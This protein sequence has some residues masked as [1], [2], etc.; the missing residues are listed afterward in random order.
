MD[1]NA[2]FL[3]KYNISGPRYTSYPPAN[4]FNPGFTTSDY[5]SE[6]RA[7]NQQKPASISLY[8]HIPF[9]PQRCHFCGCSTVIAQRKKVVERY[10]Q[11]LKT[12]MKLVASLLD[13]TRRVTQIHWG[14]GTPNSISMNYIREIMDWIRTCFTV[15]EKAEIAI[16][17][18]PA[19]LD[20]SH[21]DQLADIGF[22]RISLGIQDF[23]EDVL[24]VVNREAPRHPVKEVV[25]YLRTK[26]FRGINLDFIYGLPLQ[27]LESFRHTIDQAIAIRPDRI[28]TFS[29]AHVP[30]VKA[31]QKQLE[32][33]GLPDA[34][35]KMNLFLQATAQLKEAGYCAIGI[36]HFTLPDDDLTRA[37]QNKQLHRNFQGY[38]TL[39]TTGQVYAFGSSSISQLWGA[40][41]QNHKEITK[42]MESVEECGT[43]IERGYK[44]NKGEQ[45]VRT[46]IN[47]IMCNGLLRLDE[48]ADEFG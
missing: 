48:T 36:D 31:A 37:Y 4:F 30:W 44:L 21:I 16:E 46:V 18:S 8:I 23:R 2:D 6:L 27:T 41:A 42:Y 17:C 11:A 35:D 13:H 12:E 19:Y 26:G 34:N 29:Y 14:G 7:S 24:K 43:A 39:E 47:S 38:C 10:I 3:H 15:N 28:V 20:Y 9:C 33:I 32:V 22:N 25:E 45:I 5:I 40:Y 1:I